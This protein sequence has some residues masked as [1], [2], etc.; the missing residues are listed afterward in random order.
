MQYAPPQ[1][2]P[3]AR[4]AANLAFPLFVVAVLLAEFPHAGQH[5]MKVLLADLL[6]FR[7]LDRL[8]KAAEGAFQLLLADV[9]LQIGP[10]TFTGKGAAFALIELCPALSV[11]P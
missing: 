10:A 3:A 7:E 8:F 4:I 11:E 2:R 9:K 1:R 5:R 6:V